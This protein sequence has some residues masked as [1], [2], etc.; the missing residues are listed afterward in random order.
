MGPRPALPA[1][2]RARLDSQP[3]L[4]GSC[5]A[6]QA[7]APALTWREGKGIRPGRGPT[8]SPGDALAEKSCPWSLS[9][10]LPCSG[11]CPP[12][13]P[14]LSLRVGPG[15]GPG[16]RAWQPPTHWLTHLLAHPAP[17]VWVLSENSLISSVEAWRVHTEFAGSL[18]SSLLTRHV[19]AV[20]GAKPGGPRDREGGRVGP[21]ICQRRGRNW[22]L[23]HPPPPK[24]PAAPACGS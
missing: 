7:L 14:G 13:S 3:P 15:S 10:W 8:C 19:G 18:A 23:Q 21:L 9:G 12:S 11:H 4:A 20:C 5:L 17:K 2:H 16:L 22:S 24:L 1:Q 6:P